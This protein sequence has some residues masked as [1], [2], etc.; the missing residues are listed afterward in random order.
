MIDFTALFEISKSERHARWR[1]RR[2]RLKTSPLEFLTAPAQGA[3]NEHLAQG[4]R[5]FPL[6]THPRPCARRDV[7]ATLHDGWQDF[8]ENHALEALG[9]GQFR[10]HD[11]SHFN[12]DRLRLNVAIATSSRSVS[13]TDL[14]FF[15]FKQG[16]SVLAVCFD[17]LPL[18]LITKDCSPP[19]F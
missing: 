4:P 15:E 9:S 19:S 12:H 8:L 14:N 6:Q 5:R 7:I 2:W 13:C 18:V 3:Q 1:H 16:L 11:Q 10:L 17:R